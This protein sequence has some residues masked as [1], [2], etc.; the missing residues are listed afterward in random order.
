MVGVPKE[1]DEE[2]LHDRFMRVCRTKY[3]APARPGD[4]VRHNEDRGGSITGTIRVFNPHTGQI[5]DIYGLVVREA[6]PPVKGRKLKQLL[7]VVR[8][9]QSAKRVQKLI[10]W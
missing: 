2:K 1:L 4:L 3:F 9:L 8:F 5:A 10:F 6:Q 7:K